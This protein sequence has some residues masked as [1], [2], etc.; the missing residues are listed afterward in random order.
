VTRRLLEALLRLYPPG[1]RER[2][3]A[4]MR[5]VIGRD[6]ARGRRVSAAALA[7]NALLAWVDLSWQSLRRGSIF[8]LRGLRRARG[9]GA[10]VV[11]VVAVSVAMTIAASGFLRGTLFRPRP[12]PEPE[13]L[14]FAWGSNAS[15]GRIRDVVS[16]PV[17][18]DLRR[19][20]GTLEGLAAIHGGSAVIER[21]GRPQVLDAL[22]VS[23]DFL[24]ILGV[25]PALGRDFG[26]EHRT[27]R[28]PRA[29]VLSHAFWREHFGGEG[30]AVG[31]TLVLNRSPHIVLGVMGPE[32]EFLQ[33][34][35][36][37]LPL[38]E[39]DLLAED[40]TFYYYWLIGR[41][42]PG[43]S[44][45]A[46]TRELSALLSRIAAEDPRLREW[47]VLV[48]RVDQASVAAVRPLLLALAGAV[49]LVVLAAAA[50]LSSLNLVRTLGRSRELYVRAAIGAPRS[51]LAAL[52]LVETGAL[53]VPG[54]ALGL[55][56]GLA[57]EGWLAR[58]VPGS[59]PVPGSAA[60]IDALRGAFDVSTVLSA[61]GAASLVWILMSLPSILARAVR[62]LR[63]VVAIEIALA[64][65]LLVGA[66]LLSRAADRLLAV[67]PG[68]DP[69]GLLTFYIGE[70]DE[71]D[72]AARARYFREVARR[73][74]QV[75]GVVRA[76]ATDYAPFQGEDDFMG[77]RLPDRAPPEPG[78]SPREEWRR[79]TEGFFEAAGIG[80]RRG[81]GFEGADYEAPPSVALV[82]EAFAQKYWAG[83]DPIGRRLE[84]ALPEYGLLEIVG[85]VED[86]PERGPALPPPPVFFVPLHGHPRD[87]MA[88]FVRMES[89]PLQ[90]L[91]EVKEAAWSVDSSQP[92][93]RIFPMTA[94]VE[95]AVAL[96]RLAR[97]LVSRFAAIALGLS[98]LGLFAVASYA[99]R[100]RRPE[101]GIRLALGAT[102]PRLQLELVSELALLASVGLSVGML[103]AV[104]AASLASAL[105]HGVSP[106]DPGSFGAAAAVVAGA[107][108]IST[109]VPARA[110]AR[111]DPARSIRAL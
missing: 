34:S 59:I 110:I 91:E 105:L 85:V 9:F 106:L 18:L 5:E 86:V 22:E 33:R 99:V 81:R 12:Y 52:V 90:S 93:D 40:R 1:F 78:R 89:D 54:T 57:L 49:S 61:L 16:G 82:N 84:V 101:L 83:A 13:R 39:D 77:F 38:R 104:G 43:A 92:I 60:T 70:L 19:E 67:D 108:L 109:Y 35:Q 47:S 2:Y 100:T 107:G 63:L 30:S 65:V 64:T 20:T 21:D 46:A 25:R 23:V 111:I 24:R 69:D 76:G 45:G 98:A 14:V 26:D 48:E 6:F 55:V 28:G 29:V 79:V 10:A 11:L 71:P 74:E 66:G 96:P 42:S 68:V 44:P 36:V 4:E 15:N 3:E 97:D 87:N 37:L 7:A 95:S 102:P 62:G 50:N 88:I 31:R 51:A 32:F 41:L 17:F 80:V 53:A 75:P 56:L 94:L 8:D 27:S 103:L 72:P 73:I 58:T